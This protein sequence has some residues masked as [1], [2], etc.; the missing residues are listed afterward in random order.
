MDINFEKGNTESEITFSLNEKSYVY[1]L[2]QIPDQKFLLVEE[3]RKKLLGTLSTKALFHNLLMCADLFGIANNAVDGTEVVS[4]SLWELRQKLIK[5]ASDSANGYVNGFLGNIEQVSQI[6]NFG[7]KA[8]FDTPVDVE[9]LQECFKLIGDEADEICEGASK[10][11]DMFKALTEDASEISKKIIETRATDISKK[12]QFEQNISEIEAKMKGLSVTQE[13]LQEEIEEITEEYE[14][15]DKRIDKAVNQQFLINI[16]SG[17]TSA[18]GEGLSAYTASTMGGAANH[19]SDNLSNMM[20]DL[21]NK[22]NQKNEN[23]CQ[24]MAMQLTQATLD[25]TNKK[26]LES[27]EKIKKL[28]EELEQINTKISEKVNADDKEE[29]LKEK[30][31]ISD[32]KELE[33]SNLC[34]LKVEAKTHVDTINGISAGLESISG[35]LDQQSEKIEDTVSILVK[36]ADNIAERRAVLKKEKR[37][38][39]KMMAEY[40]AIVENSVVTKNSLDL[41]IAALS[42][43]ITALNY[44]VS[45][46]N[47]FYSFWQ[48]IKSYCNC[49]APKSLELYF[50]F[51][52]KR[53]EK[54]R[55]IDFLTQFAINACQWVALRGVLEEYQQAFVAMYNKLQEQLLEDQDPNPEA[56]WQ[57]AIERSKGMSALIQIQSE[58]F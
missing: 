17:V 10:L 39:L 11:V 43:A 6:Y 58:G 32:Q 53:P 5:T 45:V 36:K 12:K 52:K 1:N 18:I 27:E 35:K 25:S 21:S 30:K 40:T 26:I 29:L 19:I 54:F 28:S 57:R 23:S 31:R 56:M 2:K 16:I 33:E 37:E 46:L 13:N 48:K 47:D 4:S 7:V 8:L 34:A 55:S 49:L 14:R 9:T 50:T 42:A 51:Y 24:S 15:L 22:E 38:I 44:I 3:E 20:K 41:A